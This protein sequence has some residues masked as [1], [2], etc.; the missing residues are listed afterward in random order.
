VA[1]LITT[2]SAEGNLEMIELLAECGVDL[3]ICGLEGRGIVHVA[4]SNKRLDVL[5]F[6]I[7]YSATILSLGHEHRHDSFSGYE[8]KLDVKDHFGRTPLD[9]CKVL[10]WIEGEAVLEKGIKNLF[11]YT[12]KN[13][14]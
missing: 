12:T 4:V 8:I 11:E 6:L 5:E 10:G 13:N 3:N 7:R 9:E 2:A 14:K 1:S